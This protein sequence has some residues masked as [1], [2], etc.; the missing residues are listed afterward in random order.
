MTHYT[1]ADSPNNHDVEQF[2]TSVQDT[3]KMIQEFHQATR[4][5]QQKMTLF[6]TPQ[7]N[8]VNHQQLKELTDKGKSLVTRINKRLQDLNKACQGATGRTRR[9]QVNKL[10]N[11]YKNQLK[12]FE[13]TCQKLV[14]NEKAAVANIRRQSSSFQH[15]ETNK[16][17]NVGGYNEDQIYSQ[18]NVTKYD[19][20][21]MLE[22]F[23]SIEY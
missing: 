6:N 1:S 7:D 17:A 11:D 20:D 22:H 15:D 19:E 5:I 13:E 9:T 14:E 16:K 10:S 21:G 18:V 3:S 2:N 12:S 4:S 23:F 8:R